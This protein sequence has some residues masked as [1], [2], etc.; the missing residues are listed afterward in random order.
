MG[1]VSIRQPIV[2]KY[3]RLAATRYASSQ[4]RSSCTV[5]Q[6][7]EDKEWVYCQ[8][9]DASGVQKSVRSKFLVGCDGKTGFTRKSYLEPKGVMMEQ[10]SSWV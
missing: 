10:I 3:L 7:E 8:Y 5:V 1:V 2:E 4:L 9:S 6:I